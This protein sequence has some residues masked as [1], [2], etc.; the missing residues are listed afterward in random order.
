MGVFYKFEIT[1]W[2][3]KKS[4]P[5][6]HQTSRVELRGKGVIKWKKYWKK[7]KGGGIEK[8]IIYSHSIFPCAQ[9]KYS[10]L[11]YIDWTAQAH[12]PCCWLDHWAWIPT[13]AYA[14]FQQQHPSLL[15]IILLAV[16]KDGCPRK[17][18]MQSDYVT[19]FFFLTNRLCNL[20]QKHIWIIFWFYLV[21][22]PG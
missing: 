10:L 22:Y 13:A 8:M 6:T 16:P 12:P 20:Q 3:D 7:Q 2:N 1:L 18:R 11:L 21:S 15:K 4:V 9:S 5:T 19:F 17:Q 14:Q